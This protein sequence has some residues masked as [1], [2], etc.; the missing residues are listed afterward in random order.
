MRI[1]LAVIA[2]ALLVSG[3]GSWIY[4]PGSPPPSPTPPT[5]PTEPVVGFDVLITQHDRAVAVRVG[6][7]VEVFLVQGSGMTPW[8]AISVED[9]SV[10]GPAPINFMAPQG[11]TV[12]GFV[13]LRPGTAN[14]TSTAGPLCSPGQACPAYAVLFSVTVTVT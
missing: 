6:Q 12:A 3:C 8:E 7:K 14:I 2:T 13:A 10:L 4:G 11:V 5:V 9:P 1:L